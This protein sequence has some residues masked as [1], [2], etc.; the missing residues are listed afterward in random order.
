MMSTSRL[1]ACRYATSAYT[2]SVSSASEN[3]AIPWYSEQCSSTL[4]S[5]YSSGSTRQGERKVI[6]TDLHNKC[7]DTHTGTSASSPMAAGIIALMLEAN[8][9]LGWRDVQH[10]IVRYEVKTTCD[11]AFIV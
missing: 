8:P 11:Q 7:T 4:A 3:G 5:T 10:I 9:G 1:T 2:V 6:T